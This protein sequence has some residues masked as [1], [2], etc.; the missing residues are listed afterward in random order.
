MTARPA[1]AS[2]TNVARPARWASRETSAGTSSATGRAGRFCPSSTTSPRWG[3]ARGRRETPISGAGGS[4]ISSSGSTSS[5]SRTGS[6]STSTCSLRASAG[7]RSF[8]EKVNPQRPAAAVSPDASEDDPR[9]QLARLRVLRAVARQSSCGVRPTPERS[10]AATRSVQV[11]RRGRRV[12]A[13]ASRPARPDRLAADRRREPSGASSSGAATRR[14]SPRRRGPAGASWSGRSSAR[15]AS[16][17][18][19]GSRSSGACSP[20]TASSATGSRCSPA[21]ARRLVPRLRGPRASS[22]RP[23]SARVFLEELVERR[24]RAGGAKQLFPDRVRLAAGP[25]CARPDRRGG[26]R[27]PA[28]DVLAAALP[29]EGLQPPDRRALLADYRRLDWADARFPPAA[30][31]TSSRSS[32]TSAIPSRT[33]TSSRELAARVLDELAD[34]TEVVVLTSGSSSTSTAS[35]FRPASGSTT[36]PRGSARRTTWPCRPPRRAGARLCLHVR[37]LLVP[38]SDARR[39]DRCALKT[40]RAVQ[41]RSTSTSCGRR[42]RTPTTR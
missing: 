13:A 7:A 37:R 24:R 19:T 39:A 41:P 17:S 26:R 31:P 14:R 32:S 33:T 10:A 16:S 30:R 6:S 15:S 5:A 21:A 4:A 23:R 35:G 36:R 2:C 18:C 38:R 20:S 1:R 27:P 28:A 22:A 3:T 29:L 34:E 11:P 12:G 25:A 42:S 40:P 8:H 9:L